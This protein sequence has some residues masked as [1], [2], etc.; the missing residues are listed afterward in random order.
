M[1][2]LN[3]LILGTL[4]L[5]GG[6]C[7]TIELH[8]PAESPPGNSPTA[9]APTQCSTP[10]AAMMCTDGLPISARENPA[11]QGK[12]AAETPRVTT[13]KHRVADA[14]QE[15]ANCI[16]PPLQRLDEIPVA[17]SEPPPSN[18]ILASFEVDGDQ[19]IGVH[20]QDRA[21]AEASLRLWQELVLRI[22]TNQRLDLVE[23]RIFEGSDRSGYVDNGG[24][25]SSSQ[26]YGSIMSL[27][28]SNLERNPEDPCAPL[29]RRRGTFDWTLIHEFGHL[30][31]YADGVV[32]QYTAAFPTRTGPGEGYP[33]EGTPRLDGEWVSS[34]A[35]RAGGDEDCAE[36]FTAF[37]MLDEVPQGDSLAQQKIRWFASLPGYPELRRA[38]RITEPD[39]SD[40]P[41]APAPRLEFPFTI[42]PATWMIGD[43]TGTLAGGET[44]EYL[45]TRDDIVRQRHQADGSIERV[46]Y[47]ELRDHQL[48]TIDLYESN[49][50]FYLH[51]VSVAG[52]N[53]SESFRR[54][55]DTLR[56]DHERL[57]EFVLI[58]QDAR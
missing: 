27:N 1:N 5:L 41:I 28:R 55:E 29:S 37:V 48:A 25:E 54:Q 14:D 57:G 16:A 6:S 56:I 26:R 3:R 33:E 58:R 8:L 10:E 42:T 34:Y 40:A 43:W 52:A 36:S 45:I 24:T 47:R 32:N 19:L 30:R 38:L 46:C 13:T 31:T 18:Q 2:S 50:S 15:P 53:F 11:V 12:A 35:E 21:I 22:P 39:G 9:L 4:S 23:F 51:Q 44:I 20:Y 7:L 49:N 17:S